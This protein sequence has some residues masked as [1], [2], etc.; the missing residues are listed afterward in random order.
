MQMIPGAAFEG[1][2]TKNQV[3]I[4]RVRSTQ[5]G[6]LEAFNTLVLDYQDQVYNQ[7]FWILGDEAAAEDAAQ[8]AFY[9]AYVKIGT[10]NGDSFRAWILRIATN[11][12]LD[13]IRRSKRHP[14]IS[15]E[16]PCP[17]DNEPNENSTWLVDSHH[18]PEQM[19]ELSDRRALINH[20]LMMLAPKDRTPII[21]VDIQGL[22]Y[23]EAAEALGLPLG[24]LKSRLCRARA[25]LLQHISRMPGSDAML[26]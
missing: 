24:S 8:E 3:D 4:D 19:V 10:F 14:L 9:R 7:A 13:C 26:N 20:C 21:L 25:K 18:T 6:S 5:Q 22:D 15:L 11:Y 17:E 1:S 16:L 2:R 12:C 23:Q